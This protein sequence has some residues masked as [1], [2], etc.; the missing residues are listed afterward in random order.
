MEFVI[1]LRILLPSISDF[2]L[3]DPFRTT[4][5]HGMHLDRGPGIE[6]CWR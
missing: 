1:L 6:M 5:E 4:N 3:L 2:C